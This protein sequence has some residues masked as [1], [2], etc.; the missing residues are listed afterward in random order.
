MLNEE[1]VSR[2]A[3]F[4]REYAEA[5]HL[6]SEAKRKVAE[7]DSLFQMFSALQQEKVDLI[8]RL[9]F[10]KGNNEELRVQLRQKEAEIEELKLRHEEILLEKQREHNIEV[11]ELE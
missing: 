2:F 5:L 10:E 6:A 11:N 1:N 4:Q 3:E 8:K 9:T 7:Y